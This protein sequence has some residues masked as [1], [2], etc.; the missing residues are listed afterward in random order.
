MQ[1]YWQGD[2]FQKQGVFWKPM[3]VVTHSLSQDLSRLQGKCSGWV[4]S[5]AQTKRNSVTRSFNKPETN[6]WHTLVKQL[7]G[8]NSCLLVHF[9]FFLIC[10]LWFK[11][12]KMTELLWEIMHWVSFECGG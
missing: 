7:R 8:F 11:L 5:A 10:L 3:C 12:I 6:Q 2:S 9:F 1:V 4:F